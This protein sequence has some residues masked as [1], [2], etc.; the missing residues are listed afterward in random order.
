[1]GGAHRGGALWVNEASAQWASAS[2][3]PTRGRPAPVCL[4]FPTKK[5]TL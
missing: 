5:G 2:Q 3:G 4:F 1:M